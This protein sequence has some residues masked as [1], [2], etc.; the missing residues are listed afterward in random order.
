LNNLEGEYDVTAIINQIEKGDA[1]LVVDVQKD[2]CTGGRL[3]VERGDQV[4]P[5]LNRWSDH[6]RK[7]GIPIY[8]SRDW[9]PLGHISFKAQGGKWPPHCIQDS[10]GARFHAELDLAPDVVKITKG[11]RFDQDQNSVFDQTGLTDRLRRDSVRRLWIGGLA[12]DVCVK[13]SVLDALE[14]GFEVFILKEAT[15]PVT[16]EGGRKSIDFMRRAGAHIVV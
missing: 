3:A 8:A 15:R 13:A 2:F 12:L 10:D 11:V 4:V 16:S 14:E 5:V 7:K 1:L 6:A 9:H